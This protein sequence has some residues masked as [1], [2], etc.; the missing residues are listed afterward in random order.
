MK[1]LLRDLFFVFIPLIALYLVNS[2]SVFLWPHLLTNK[3]FENMQNEKVSYTPPNMDVSLIINKCI[4][5][6]PKYDTIIIGS[7]NVKQFCANMLGIEGTYMNMGVSAPEFGDIIGIWENIKDSGKIPSRMVIGLDSWYMDENRSATRYERNWYNSYATYANANFGLNLEMK[8]HFIEDIRFLSSSDFFM[9]SI[10]K[11]SQSQALFGSVGIADEIPLKSGIALMPDG[12]MLYPADYI[13]S[14]DDALL[15][16]YTELPSL[17]YTIWTIVSPV[18]IA[19]LWTLLSDI[20]S[21]G[22]DIVLYLSPAHPLIYD[23]YVDPPESYTSFTDLEERYQSIADSLDIPI[24][25]SFNPYKC[26][27]IAED[28]IDA[29]HLNTLTVARFADE[30]YN[31]F[32]NIAT[33]DD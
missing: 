27:V 9:N 19:L 4:E 17:Q 22:V 29:R 33:S 26:C 3:V 12:S 21:Y 7:S 5:D 1:K 2:V 14:T 10:E 30:I 32:S 13:D 18:R 25:G 31:S 24:V 16:A 11:I 6:G 28:F 23:A 15:R 8:N 20:Q